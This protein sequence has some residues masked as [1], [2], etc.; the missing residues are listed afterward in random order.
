MET[1]PSYDL[2]AAAENWRLELTSQTDLTD[3]D[4]RELE[5]HL[6]DT[7]AELRERGL[8]EEESFLLARRRIGPTHEIAEEFIK[9]NP[10]KVWRERIMWALMFKL[11]FELWTST[12]SMF[13]WWFNH[14]MKYADLM[15]LQ[16]LLTIFLPCAP[17][18]YFVHWVS[19]NETLVS[20]VFIRRS[21]FVYAAI[22]VS[23]AQLL[24]FAAN[25]SLQHQSG[26]STYL[27]GLLFGLAFYSI[28]IGLIAWLHPERYRKAAA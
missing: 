28:P 10:G 21:R 1:H 23:A 11:I 22:G 18:V 25:L 24:G 9:A 8:N 19:Q 27:N 13:E 12:T 3:E 7:I 5:T 4:R 2:N 16:V 6:W 26:P 17:L 15:G 14:T 20:S